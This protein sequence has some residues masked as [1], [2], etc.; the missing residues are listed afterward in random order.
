MTRLVTIY[1]KSGNKATIK[2]TTLFEDLRRHFIELG[3]AQIP[4]TG[5]KVIYD[6]SIIALEEI[7]AVFLEPP[8]L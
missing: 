1:F 3:N 7:E 5:R 6:N 4:L 8:A 2:A